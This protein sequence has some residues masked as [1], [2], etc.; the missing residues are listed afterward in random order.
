MLRAR[1]SETH[2]SWWDAPLPHSTKKTYA[3]MMLAE[4][5]HHSSIL[6]LARQM[7]EDTSNTYPVTQRWIVLPVPGRTNEEQ[8]TLERAMEANSAHIQEMTYID[9]TGV[10]PMLN[11]F[12]ITPKTYHLHVKDDLVNVQPTMQTILGG[13]LQT[14]SEVMVSPVDVVS[15]AEIGRWRC[16]ASTGNVEQLLICITSMK[17]YVILDLLE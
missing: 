16:R 9:L 4:P 5:H 14:G 11:L 12:T 6:T 2:T 7:G 3:M 1:G 10:P 13:A 8:E 15:R 17:E